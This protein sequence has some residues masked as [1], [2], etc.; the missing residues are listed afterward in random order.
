MTH[1]YPCTGPTRVEGFGAFLEAELGLPRH[2]LRAF[3]RELGQRLAAPAVTLVNSGSSANLAAALALR[4]RTGRPRALVAGFTFPTTV[5]ALQL[6]GFEVEVVDTATFGMAEHALAA[7]L[8]P[9]VGVVCV[10]QFLGFPAG[11]PALAARA[12]AAGALVLQ[13]AC[14]TMGLLEDGV[15][16]HGFADATTY[17]F[18]HPHHLSS[19]GGGA[20]VCRDAGLSRVVESVAHWGRACTCHLD[21]PGC[22]APVGDGHQFHYVR[23]GQNLEM[24]ELNACFGRFSLRA[25]AADEARRL[26]HYR[27][28]REAT[29]GVLEGW[30][31]PDAGC[32]PFVFPF[33]HPAAAE[34]SRRLAARGVE[35]RTLMGGPVVDQPAFARLPHDGLRRCRALAATTRF[36]GVHHTL[37]DDDVA[38]V[39]ELLVDEA[40]ACQ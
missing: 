31:L 15:P 12:E 21:D 23:A 6:S 18:Y 24:S 36:V 33:R 4:E 11:L 9:D 39:A 7:A 13:D 38:R 17:S 26:R 14:E 19:F 22:P 16:I 32:S 25:F 29:R 1:R 20:V 37:P 40:R 10:T 2:N 35:V 8:G 34:L 27:V 5:S 3:A 30:D 28:L